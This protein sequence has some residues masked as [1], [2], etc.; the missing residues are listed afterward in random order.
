MLKEKVLYFYGVHSWCPKNLDF[1]YIRSQS[2]S[3]GYI[4]IVKEGLVQVD[5]SLHLVILV[6]TIS[7]ENH[8]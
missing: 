2:V 4:V 3:I 5:M 8:Y 6:Y 1:I 7:N